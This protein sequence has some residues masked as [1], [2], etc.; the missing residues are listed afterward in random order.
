MLLPNDIVPFFLRT[1]IIRCF[2]HNIIQRLPDIKHILLHFYR[3]N[4]AAVHYRYVTVHRHM[5]LHQPHKYSAGHWYLSVIFSNVHTGWAKKVS[6]DILHITLSNTGRCSKSFHWHNLHEIY[7]K[8]SLNIPPHLKCVATTTTTTKTTTT[9]NSNN[10]NNNNNNNNL[11]NGWLL[12]MEHH[13][14]TFVTDVQT[15]HGEKQFGIQE[16]H[17]NTFAQ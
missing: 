15:Q 12:Q 4:N 5:L 17:G 10:N 14:L 8:H 16:F 3:I 2:I 1:F 7:K 6:P 11:Q 13:L 9:N